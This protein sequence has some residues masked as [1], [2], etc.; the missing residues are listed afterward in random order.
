MAAGDITGPDPASVDSPIGGY[1]VPGGVGQHDITYGGITE[2]QLPSTI[3]W[4]PSMANPSTFHTV[5]FPN[6]YQNGD[7]QAEISRLAAGGSL[8]DLQKILVAAG[9]LPK[10]TSFGLPDN[11]T[12]SLIAEAMA[13]ANRT[14]M[15]YQEALQQMI[16]GGLTG[17][18]GRGGGGGAARLLP[19]PDDV[20]ALTQ[21]TS[22]KLIGKNLDEPAL[23]AAV[24]AFYSSY[25]NPGSGY[26]EASPTT[27][28]EQYL[29]SSQPNEVQ[30]HSAVNA[31]ATIAQMLNGV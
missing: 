10:D 3:Q 30:A 15:T 11:S 27:I 28:S 9:L 29:R 20:K 16:S 2:D 13:I 7:A 8:G 4:N 19:N 6:G 22:Q 31:Y 24:N 25:S 26:S 1:H 12:A 21:T 23:Q 5:D 18:G 17:G 14:G